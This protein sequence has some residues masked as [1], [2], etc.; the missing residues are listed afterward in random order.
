MPTN[1]AIMPIPIGTRV[2]KPELI[3]SVTGLTKSEVITKLETVSTIILL[4]K[5]IDR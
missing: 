5:K 3:A 4:S 2:V 1:V